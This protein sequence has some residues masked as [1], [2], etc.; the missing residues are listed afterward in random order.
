MIVQGAPVRSEAEVSIEKPAN[1]SVTPEHKFEISPMPSTSKEPPTK[2][3]RYEC[4]VIEGLK[5]EVKVLKQRVKRRD[6]RIHSIKSLLNVIKKKT[7]D[8][9]EI[10]SVIKTNFVHIHEQFNYAI[11]KKK[12]RYSE[13][14]KS[15]ALTLHFYS[16]KAYLFLRKHVCLPH[17]AT[18]RRLLATRDCSVG[19]IQEV[20]MFLKETAA[21]DASLKNVA[22]LFDSMAIRT[23]LRYDKKTDKYWGYVDY[24]GILPNECETLASEALVFM[25]VSYTKR[26]KCPIAYFFINKISAELQSQL[27]LTAIRMLSE[28]NITVR[29]LTCDGTCVNVKTYEILGC[30]FTL[31]EMTTSFKHPT[32][33]CQIHCIL[34]PP[35]MLKLSRNV[36]AETNMTSVKGD[37]QFNFIKKLDAIQE[38]EGLKLANKLT[39]NHVGFAGKK[40]NVKL[41][42]QVLSNSVADAIEFLAKCGDKRFEGSE[43]TVEYIRVLDRIFDIFN[44]KNPFGKGFK[45]PLRLQNTE[46]W[47][48]ALTETRNYLMNL[49]INDTNILEHRR[50][51]PALGFII[52]T[53]SFANLCL[54]LLK[55]STLEMK[56]FLT[57]KCSQDN[58]EIFFSCVR[59]C[60]ALN[61]NPSSLQFRYTLRKLLFRNSVEPSVNAN[62]GT[63]DD[64]EMT[65]VLE[66][67]H[68]KRAI[69]E[70]AEASEDQLI[71]LLFYVD[72]EDFSYYKNNILYYM[73][74]CC[75]KKISEKLSCKH[76]LAALFINK[77]H[78]DHD[79]DHSIDVYKVSSFTSFIDRGKLKYVSKFV[80]QIILYTEKIFKFHSSESLQKVNKVKIILFVLQNF[81]SILRNYFD[82]PHPIQSFQC[83]DSHEMQLI[84]SIASHYLTARMMSHGKTQTLKIIGHKS[85][86]RQKL[87][88]TVLF[89][90]V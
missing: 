90:N 10:E 1:I 17:P 18:L 12:V 42:A 32:K 70:N 45:S 82:P 28:A 84:K 55:D 39:S 43:A 21:K 77:E 78:D 15:F 63:E 3:I 50:K 19:F 41:A 81:Y 80:F 16:P 60:G 4:D 29:S 14:L 54:D 6:L 59:R 79:Y 74:G 27:I 25:I 52:D 49:K 46:I 33:D 44:S 47:M 86:L 73:A 68:P 65:P 88:K 56:Y 36:F 38:E 11:N 9:E 72:N 87:H 85:T 26:F 66:F 20:L 89:S 67:R 69:I 2:K 64:F 83:E 51:T 7:H 34:D 31:P 37:I 8:P 30:K 22:L 53:F 40:M 24:G 13:E 58:L 61:D 62:C 5:R 35:H 76:C 75:A 57:Y 71:D 48:N 23:E